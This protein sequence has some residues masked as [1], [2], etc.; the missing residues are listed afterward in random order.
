MRRFGG[1]SKSLRVFQGLI[2]TLFRLRALSPLAGGVSR[3][4]GERFAFESE[5]LCSVEQCAV[6]DDALIDWSIFR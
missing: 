6:L 3:R 2:K 4:A 5:K 1:P